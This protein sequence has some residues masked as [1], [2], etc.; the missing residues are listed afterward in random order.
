MNWQERAVTFNCQGDQLVGV[1][2]TPVESTLASGTGVLVVVGGPQYR[3]GAHRQFVQLARALAGV[4]HSVLRF[5]VRG[6]GDSTGAPRGFEHLSDDISAALG[7]LKAELPSLQQLVI[8]GLC[9]GASAALLYLHRTR[10]SRIAGL[11]LLN[12]WVRSELSLARAQV[13]HYYA[14]RF[15]D[16]TFWRRLLRGEVSIGRRLVEF[17]GSLRSSLGQAEGRGD[18]HDLTFQ[19]KMADGLAKFSGRCQIALSQHDITAQE[20]ADALAHQA[21]WRNVAEAGLMG[22][23]QVVHLSNADHTLSGPNDRQQFEKGL[24]QWLNLR[25]A[26]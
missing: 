10:D 24:V 20:F 8:F 14:E 22:Q 4:G 9:D 12:P 18:E 23:V 17:L 11:S 26:A 1:L 2:A 13:K 5:D 21:I 3:A 15:L 7:A 25:G 16:R 6:M 19:E